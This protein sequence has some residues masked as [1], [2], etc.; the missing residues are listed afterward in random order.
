[1]EK[2]DE[3]DA[4]GRVRLVEAPGHRPPGRLKKTWKKNMEEELNRFQLCAVQAPDRS[5]WRTIID[6]LTF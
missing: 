1:M 5:G 6:R 3:R 2:R 4:L